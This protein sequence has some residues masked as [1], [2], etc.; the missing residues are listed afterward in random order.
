[1]DPTGTLYEILGLEP[2]ASTEQVQRAYTF[3]CELYDENALATYSLLDP[4]QVR[5]VR[6]R[7]QEAY[8]TLRDPL[9][10]RKYDM[11]LGLSVEPVLV[12]FPPS[13][14]GTQRE[15]PRAGWD[16][17]A[18]AQLAE[19]VTG[20]S[21]KRFREER[22]ISLRQIATSSKIGVRFLE[23]IEADR[24]SCLPAPVYLRGFVQ[25][26]A[27][28]VGLDPRPTA[29]AYLASLPKS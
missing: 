8:E 11:S 17:P 15:I 26:Y 16:P 1:M 24:H 27:R 21:L 2:R 29:E 7:I 22:G 9:P 14:S 4:G 13:P 10:R 19:P 18:L 6:A 12:P 20:A 5:E 3:L 28:V 23:Y 25:E